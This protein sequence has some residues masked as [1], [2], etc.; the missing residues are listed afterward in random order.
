MN[1][2]KF[3]KW[4]GFGTFG[5]VLGSGFLF[6]RPHAKN[7]YYDGPVSD[8][9]DGRIF[10]NPEGVPPG[11]FTDLLKWQLFEKRAKWP[12]A[13]P[14]PFAGAKPKTAIQEGFEVTLIGHATLLIQ[15]QGM[16]LITDPVFSHRASPVQFAGP[17]RINPPGVAFEDL[18]KID[19]VLLT[20]NH[21]D[22]LDIG[23]VGR[24]VDRDN[25]LILAPLGND[26]ILKDAV[27]KA[28]VETGDWGDV[29]RI[30]NGIAIHFEPCHHWSARGTRDRRM[31]L[32]SA[33]VIETDGAK[34]YHIGD[35]GFHSG[36]NYRA[37]AQKHGPFDLAIIPIGAYEPRWFMN[38]QH[39]NPT[40]AVEGFLACGAKAAVGHHWG[41]FQLTNEPID[42]PPALL[43]KALA[44]KKV[45]EARFVPLHP[46]ETWKPG[47][48]VA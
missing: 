33:F 17:K 9:F 18:P 26:V 24:L 37:A 32:W 16:N 10:F 39:Q 45:D 40:Q 28:N 7:L 6:T 15:I 5:G 30:G 11:K 48:R 3:M 42:E 38:G 44:E 46:G 1:R 19:C 22:H 23:S 14:S 35:T 21:Y 12:D 2:R 25:P 29:K 31:A 27:S 43:K 36:I 47:D 4:L 34:I 8:H 41:T 13:F 20:H